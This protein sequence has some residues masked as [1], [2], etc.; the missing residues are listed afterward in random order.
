MSKISYFQQIAEDESTIFDLKT[1]YE[2]E[3]IQRTK[4]VLNNE[5]RMIDLSVVDSLNSIIIQ[6]NNPVD[7]EITISA[8]ATTFQVSG[9]FEFQPTASFLSTIDLFTVTESN[10]ND[11]EVVVLLVGK[12]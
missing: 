2:T 10:S 5:T 1:N 11:T 9:K 4:M 7:I 6:T 12:E 3:E 8:V